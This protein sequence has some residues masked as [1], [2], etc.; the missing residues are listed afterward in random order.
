MMAEEKR[1]VMRHLKKRPTCSLEGAG[2]L[3][4]APLDFQ[5]NGIMT[6]L[7]PAEAPIPELAP[8]GLK[9]VVTGKQHSESTVP[10]LLLAA[11]LL[12]QRLSSGQ[13]TDELPTRSPRIPLHHRLLAS[14]PELLSRAPLSSST[15]SLPTVWECR[16]HLL[17]FNIQVSP[18]V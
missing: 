6:S 13:D 2:A 15:A 10:V 8:S 7:T 4:C 12:T 11:P 17:I 1:A 5:I 18:S 3:R 16:G 9:Q 14:L